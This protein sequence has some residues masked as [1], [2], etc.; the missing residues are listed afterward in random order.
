MRILV[1]LA[2][3]SELLSVIQSF[4]I[5]HDAVHDLKP[6]YSTYGIYKG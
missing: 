2:A 4:T 6:S 3:V 5:A 1:R